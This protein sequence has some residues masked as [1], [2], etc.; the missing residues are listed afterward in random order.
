MGGQGGLGWSW[1]FG[2]PEPGL[3]SLYSWMDQE[4][5]RIADQKGGILGAILGTSWGIT[6]GAIG[7]LI[8][9]LGVS[10]VWLPLIVLPAVIATVGG[11]VWYYR[12][13]SEEER[14]VARIRGEAKGVLQR[15]TMA[16][17]TGKLKET[18]GE[19]AAFLLNEAAKE[20]IRC[21]AALDSPVFKASG[22]ESPWRRARDNGL[23]SMDAAMAR[24]VLFAGS[25]SIISRADGT[26]AALLQDMRNMADESA[27]H[28][29]RLAGRT[30]ISSGDASSDLRRS[31]GELRMLSDADDE[32][33]RE[34]EQMDI[35]GPRG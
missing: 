22:A 23:R 6:G 26:A 33:D 35:E 12:A 14:S 15:L 30:G 21:R 19:D 1:V 34:L 31:I 11:L 20:W 16:R 29:E 8:G 24:M 17:W 2:R 28:A 18:L 25:G 10:P 5:H 3:E 7:G 9:G 27:K 13:R 32:L 4:Q